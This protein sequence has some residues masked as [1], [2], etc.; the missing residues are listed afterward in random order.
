[1]GQLKGVILDADSLHPADLDLSS[2]LNIATISWQVYSTSTPDT[3]LERVRPADVVLTNKAPVR[4]P[5][6]D[7]APHLKY[8]GILA[9]GTN[10]VDLDAARKRNITTTNITNYGTP[11]VVQHTFA[12]ILALTT[13]LNNYAQSSLNRRWSDSDY[14]CLLDFPVR[15]LSGLTLGII[16]YG[17]LGR[18]VAAIGKAFGMHIIVADLPGRPSSA[19]DVSRLPLESFLAQ[20]DIVSL[21]CPLADNTYHLIGSRELAL[22]KTD[23]LLINCAR[24]SIVDE[25]ALASA[26]I[27]GDIAGA[28]LDVLS[29]EPPPPDHILLSGAIPNLIVTPH[30]AWGA[31]NARQRLV[32]QAG[33]HL[34]NWLDTANSN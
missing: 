19:S 2:L 15:E 27:N 22:M 28:A 26:L 6:I 12:L 16:G 29:Q 10:A 9:T 5:E 33:R 23:S 20:A 21:H 17:V 7:S 34:K 4:A 25:Q 8:I 3:V 31:R 14:F 32:D 18:A 1:M 24:G 30:C 13:Q 11:S